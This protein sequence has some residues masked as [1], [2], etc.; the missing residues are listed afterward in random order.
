MMRWLMLLSATAPAPVTACGLSSS[1]LFLISSLLFS[2]HI[3][4]SALVKGMLPSL[5][6]FHSLS[7]K[8]HKYNVAAIQHNTNMCRD[9]GELTWSW[10][11][12]WIGHKWRTS[13]IIHCHCGYFTR[14]WHL[15]MKNIYC[16]MSVECTVGTIKAQY[17]S[18][19]AKIY[20]KNTVPQQ[21]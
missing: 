2:L 6:V 16:W 10:T 17:R 5:P 15:F 21:I 3:Y 13:N 12:T 1:Y 4:F 18:D 9:L 19:Q 14:L 11:A 7:F 20:T 8:T